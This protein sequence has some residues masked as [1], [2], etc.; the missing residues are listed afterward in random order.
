M[1]S[2]AWGES[3]M[4]KF[5]NEARE[6]GEKWEHESGQNFLV[7]PKRWAMVTEKNSCIGSTL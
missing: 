5:F 1:W 6:E 7:C 2:T 3:A 4:L